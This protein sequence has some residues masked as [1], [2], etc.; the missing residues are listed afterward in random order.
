MIFALAHLHSIVLLL[1]SNPPPPYGN[2][3]KTL[4]NQNSFK[5]D[6]KI[7]FKF[8]CMQPGNMQVRC[9]LNCYLGLGMWVCSQTTLWFPRLPA[10]HKCCSCVLLSSQCQPHSQTH[11]HHGS[12]RHTSSQRG[13]K[14]KE[15]TNRL[16]LEQNT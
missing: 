2:I 14:K 4:S 6:S 7:T 16:S 5:K 15:V 10:A 8:N 12:Q 1:H 13:Q 11:L 9:C 3:N